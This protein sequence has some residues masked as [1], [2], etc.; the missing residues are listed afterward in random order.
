MLLRT[1][2]KNTCFVISTWLTVSLFG[3][4]S[5]VSFSG[6][7]PAPV[8]DAASPFEKPEVV[9]RISTDEITESSGLAVSK[10]QKDVFWTHNDSGDGAF[11][12]AFNS[13]GT[14]LGTWKLTGARNIDWED[15]ATVKASDGRCYLYVGEIGDNDNRRDVHG[16]YRLVEPLASNDTA[17]SSKK[18]PI[19]VDTFEVLKFRYPDSR[20]NAETLLVHPANL[21]IY[22]ITKRA[23][24]AA[25]VFELKPNFDPDEIQSASRVAEISLPSGPKG[26]VTGGDISPDGKRVVLCDYFS[27]F[28]LV[29]PNDASGF[30]DIWPQKLV[31]FDLGPREI[32]ESIAYAEDENTVFATTENA[33]PP[34]IRVIRKDKK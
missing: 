10:C 24:G 20:H 32:G 28:E 4:C 9:A 7:E 23:D 17:S 26:L 34:L 3:S 16:V 21:D 18:D 6:S 25:E 31:A 29:L 27:G 14:K 19:P 33:D 13:S 30:D 12:Y 2:T 11:L 5:M 1:I 15:M 8:D 22:V